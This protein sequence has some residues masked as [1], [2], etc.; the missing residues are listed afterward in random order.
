MLFCLAPV[1]F[2]FVGDSV[3]S[4]LIR[5]ADFWSSPGVVFDGG[6]L[7]PAGVSILS[8]LRLLAVIV[9][10]AFVCSWIGG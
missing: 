9:V 8:D 1:S 5:L 6:V 7:R 3:I 10:P 4:V 2:L